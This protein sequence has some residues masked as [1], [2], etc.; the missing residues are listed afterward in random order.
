MLRSNLWLRLIPAAALIVTATLVAVTTGTNLTTLSLSL[1]P[2]RAAERH[3]RMQRSDN[4]FPALWQER[5]KGGGAEFFFTSHARPRL[6]FVH[7]T[8]RNLP[9]EGGLPNGAPSLSATPTPSGAAA[10]PPLWAQPSGPDDEAQAGMTGN[11]NQ[12]SP[13]PSASQAPTPGG[14]PAPAA[15]AGA[16]NSEPPPALD[17]STIAVGPDL[18]GQSLAAQIASADTPARAASLRLT[19]QARIEL[20]NNQPDDALRTLARA[21]SI[22]PDNPFEYYFLGRAWMAK[23]NYAQALT[24]FKR[25]EIGFGPMPNWLGDAIS[26]EGTCYEALGDD[27]KALNAYRNALNSAPDNL[28]ARIGLSRLGGTLTTEASLAQPPPNSS[29]VPGAPVMNAPAPPPPVSDAAPPPAAQPPA[30]AAP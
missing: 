27:E 5:I 23:H 13:A 8:E 18:A 29:G 4:P 11:G 2:G 26:Y 16:L 28:K 20:Q 10:N 19:E 6:I 7:M 21:V 25:A 9:P 22:D 15:S 17:A 3:K 14:Q 1:V 12:N 30:P 24:F